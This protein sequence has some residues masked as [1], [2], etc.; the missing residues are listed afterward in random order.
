MDTES[1][2]SFV[3]L[4]AD[5]GMINLLRTKSTQSDILRYNQFKNQWT[6]HNL[7]PNTVR[8]LTVNLSGLQADG[9][10]S[11]YE[12]G[13]YA[14]A[15]IDSE[16]RSVQLFKGSTPQDNGTDI[17]TSY[18]SPVFNFPK[19]T[20]LDMVRIGTV[21]DATTTVYFYTDSDD[22]TSQVNPATSE[23]PYALNGNNNYTV[24]TFARG[25]KHQVKFQLTGEQ[26]VRFFELQFR[27]R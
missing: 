18:T 11:T 7:G 20:R 21:G 13:L 10:S 5:R 3:D 25:Y 15:T 1:N 19:P 9:T 2:S 22:V 17:F 14:I 26:T 8:S 24:R 16:V 12:Q 23:T 6:R 4:A 27:S